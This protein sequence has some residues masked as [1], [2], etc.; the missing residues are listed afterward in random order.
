MQ[1][2]SRSHCT[3]PFGRKGL[4]GSRTGFSGGRAF[5]LGTDRFMAP[6]SN[7]LGDAALIRLKPG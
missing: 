6:I 4:F 3:R 1:R 2:R 5:G 7:K